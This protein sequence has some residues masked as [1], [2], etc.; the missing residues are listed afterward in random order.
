LPAVLKYNLN[1]VNF[2]K[3]IVRKTGY[4]FKLDYE[5]GKVITKYTCGVAIMQLPFYLCA[6]A[7]TNYP[8]LEKDGFSFWYNKFIDVSA[9]FYLLFGL[10][11][12]FYY[13]R[14]YFEKA[15]VYFIL[16]VIFLGT[17]LYYYSIDETGM[18]H[19]YS[20]SLFSLFLLV[21]RKTDYFSKM[22]TW[23]IA[24]VGILIGLIVLV[25][26]SNILFAIV[27]FFLDV[28]NRDQIQIRIKNIL[29]TKFFVICLLSIS[30]AI[31][32]QLIYWKYSYGN[33]ITYSYGS[34]TFEWFTP[35][36]FQTWLAPNNGLFSYSPFYLFILLG[37]CFMLKSR[38]SNGILSL[39]VFLLISYIFSCWWD[40][41][42]GCSFGARSYVEYLTLFCLPVGYLQGK[43]KNFSKGVRIG[44]YILTLFF[45]CFNLKLTYS[46]DGCFYGGNWDWERYFYL[47]T[48]PTK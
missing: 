42:F 36:L 18:S 29:R 32:P 31:I 6:D 4:G 23:H 47:V 39:S 48:G 19:V 11:C 16:T 41:S 30:I 37:C 8:K 25:R 1:A 15:T 38:I 43:V 26:P 34:E 45:I 2:P 28:V 33:F 35:K 9:I 5:S 20:F 22:S 3:N 40:R 12:L 17:N 27:Y 21:I 46:Y 44:F 14:Y 13:L 24:G 10:I 7:I